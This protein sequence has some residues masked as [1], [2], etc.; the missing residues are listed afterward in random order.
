MTK[1]LYQDTHGTDEP[2]RTSMP[3]HMAL[4]ASEA[5]HNPEISLAGDAVFCI[6][7]FVIENVKGIGMPTLK[8]LFAAM[9]YRAGDSDCITPFI[10]VLVSCFLTDPPACA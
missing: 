9:L 2:T 6:Q 3:F 10:T 7:D 5:G 8:D 1:I 4:G